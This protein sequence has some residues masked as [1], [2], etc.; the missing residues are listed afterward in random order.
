MNILLKR[1]DGVFK[2][3]IT[4]FD[5]I[6]FKGMLLSLTFAEGAM[7]YLGRRGVLNKCFKEWATTSSGELCAAV[8]RY[9]MQAAGRP[10]EYLRTWRERKEELAHKRQT[11]LGIETGLIGVW[12]CLETG[13][14]F[15]AKF[16]PG[17]GR[18]VLVPY[19]TPCKH[20]YLYF[21]H[22]DY[23]F[24]SV[25]LQTWFPFH[26][27]VCLN[28]REWMRRS[29]EKQGVDFSM[30][31]NKLIHCGNWKLA[32]DALD[33][34]LDARWTSMLDG[35]L[36]TAFPTMRNV[37][38][39]SLGYYWTFWQSEWA[40]DFI[41]D[42][43]KD[44]E[45]I[46]ESL[47]RHA[48]ITG[49]S[50]RVLRYMGR[51]VT[52]SGYPRAN[53]VD[54]VSS[55]YAVYHEGLRVRHWSGSNS[56][57]VYNEHNNLRVE[58]TI[59][60]PGAFRV[61]RRKQKA[62]KNAAKQLLPLRKGVADAP[63]RAKVSQEINDR[64]TAGLASMAD[65]HPLRDVLLPLTFAFFKKGRR[66]RGLNPT[67]KDLLLLEA[68]ADP[69]FEVDGI[70]NQALRKKLARTPWG[71]GRSEKQLSAKVSRHL[72]ILRDHG[73]IRKVPGRRKYILSRKG[74]ETI[75]ALLA[76]LSA[77]TEKLM[78]ISA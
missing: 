12:S 52:K 47:L 34:Q 35:F 36:R 30:I 70:S 9:S 39:N 60:D 31:G 69:A 1:F 66:T 50:Q 43:P 14:T 11:E 51:P 23:G 19:Q 28:G 27:Q 38:G 5:R 77:S 37:L 46:M 57:K 17:S 10:V 76:M 18:P 22:E 32:Q 74:R 48:F 13:R 4:G 78:E 61:W 49:T 53:A 62:P 2:E 8:D 16:V 40:T 33:A 63:L 59:N 21:D 15:R 64:M 54:Q 56:V 55:R 45:P 3:V 67:G 26:I 75:T 68:I 29:L 42:S 58:T 44:L 25:R 72:R 7:A 20:L 41:C 24:M 73:L 6:V 65:D 71:I